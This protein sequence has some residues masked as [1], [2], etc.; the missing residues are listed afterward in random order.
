MGK[1]KKRGVAN[2]A[3]KGVKTSSSA[4]ASAVLADSGLSAGGGFIGFSSFATTSAHGPA[5]G[6]STNGDSGGVAPFYTGDDSGIGV[7]FKG[8]AKKDAT[9]KLKS[10]QELL[11]KLSH[12][13]RK[14]VAQA[15]PHYGYLFV[16]LLKSNDRR[17]RLIANTLLHIFA[18]KGFPK[19]FTRI[20]D[21]VI[22]TL[23]SAC[24]DPYRAASE[25]ARATF[26][27][28]FPGMEDRKCDRAG[29]QKGVDGTLASNLYASCDPKA[30]R[31]LQA[32]LKLL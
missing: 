15:L 24:F 23:W 6:G 25:K 31:I 7:L 21:D 27:L 30:L 1:G 26:L 3:V 17:I 20:R 4:H 5:T 19:L 12:V 13:E 29:G 32:G 9:T 16:K 22:L 18:L 8:V 11:Q 14:Q 2:R 28:V 10:L